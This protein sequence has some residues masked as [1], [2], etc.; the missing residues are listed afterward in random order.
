MNITTPQGGVINTE[1]GEA[2]LGLFFQQRFTE[3][4]YT[5]HVCNVCIV[6]HWACF[7]LHI[8]TLIYTGP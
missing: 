3:S 1:R 6:L 7:L 2:H 5:V 4:E 8:E